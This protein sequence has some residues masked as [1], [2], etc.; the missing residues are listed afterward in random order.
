[1]DTATVQLR[2]PGSP[3]NQ[4]RPANEYKH[5]LLSL[6]CL[7]IINVLHILNIL[8]VAIIS[9]KMNMLNCL[10]NSQDLEPK[11]LKIMLNKS[12]VHIL[13]FHLL[14]FGR[15]ALSERCLQWDKVE[16]LCWPKKII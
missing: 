7:I 14:I 12:L 16:S 5:Y 11:L 10:T 15:Y 2:P 8:Y 13:R 1:M 4:C 6:A 3:L 9:R